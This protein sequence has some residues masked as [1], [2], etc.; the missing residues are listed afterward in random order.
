MM[1]IMDLLPKFQP[2][3][4]GR[5][6]VVIT[7]HSSLCWLMNAKDATGRLAV[8]VLG[9]FPPSTNFNRYVVVFSDYLTRWR[10]AFPVPNAEASVIAPLLV[11]EII[12]RHGFTF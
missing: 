11:D 1:V 4:F 6:F 9:P 2:Y 3:L 5:K 8:D 12:T 10:E 7:D